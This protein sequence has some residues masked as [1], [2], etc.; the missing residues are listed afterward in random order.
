M[1]RTHLLYGLLVV[2][3]LCLILFVWLHGRN[4][5]DADKTIRDQRSSV[6]SPAV[7]DAPTQAKHGNEVL[8]HGGVVSVEDYSPPP[9]IPADKLEQIEAIH[10]SMPYSKAKEKEIEILTEGMDALSAAKYLRALNGS[11]GIYHSAVREYVDRAVAENP[12]SFEALLL[13]CQLRPPEQAAEREAGFRK[14]LEMNPNSVEALV[15]LGTR[16]AFDGRPEEAIGYLQKAS[17]LD[18]E[19]PPSTLG[20]T[21]EELGEYDK[22]LVALK[23]SYKMT[24]SPVELAHIRAIEAGNPLWKPKKREPLGQ[25]PESSSSLE[26]SPESPPHEEA[27]PISDPPDGLESETAFDDEPFLEPP[28]SGGVA[29]Q[30]AMEAEFQRLLDEYETSIGSESDP[31]AAV[32]GEIADPERESK[33]KL[34][35]DDDPDDER[36]RRKSES[37]QKRR[38]R[39]AKRSEDDEDGDDARADEDASEEDE[40]R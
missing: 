30:E 8:N 4:T 9:E 3:G 15:G 20:L 5:P 34:S 28:E 37:N 11:Y 2:G 12:D 21:Y 22:A 14:L 18:P 31:S 26:T 38:E 24:R 27:P 35:P 1:T 40:E 23:K 13:W 6:D 19:R 33:P 36:A 39:S 25:P 29:A 7:S 32:K 10:N 17:L 16:L